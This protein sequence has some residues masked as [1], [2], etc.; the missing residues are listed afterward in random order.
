MVWVLGLLVAWN[1]CQSAYLHVLTDR[2]EKLEEV[3]VPFREE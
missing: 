1:L 2:L 3:V